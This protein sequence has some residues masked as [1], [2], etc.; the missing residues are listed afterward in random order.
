MI[1]ASARRK[2][3]GFTLIEVMISLLVF[4]I[5][6]LGVIALFPVGLE[7]SKKAVDFS[8]ATVLAQWL[9]E[10]LKRQDFAGVA[11]QG[12]DVS[13]PQNAYFRYRYTVTNTIVSGT[14]NAKRV[15]IIVSWTRKNEVHAET[16]IIYLAST[17]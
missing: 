11:T 3:G 17:L 5:G 6:A 4:S 10:D 15:E 12:T 13:F 2:G 14:T 16:F 7:A 8:E 9:A 1:P